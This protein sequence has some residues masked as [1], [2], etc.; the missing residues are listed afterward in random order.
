MK[1]REALL[2]D[3]IGVLELYSAL[4]DAD[5]GNYDNVNST[6]II[7]EYIAD[8]IS[9][10]INVLHMVKAIEDEVSKYD[11][12]EVWLGN[13]METPTPINTKQELLD[14]LSIEE[15]DLDEVIKL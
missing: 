7:K 8:M 12:W 5:M 3:N 2:N 11:L 1:I 6:E 14:A 4:I 13:S 9:K 15:E 10:D